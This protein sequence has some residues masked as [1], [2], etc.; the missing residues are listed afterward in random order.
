MVGVSVLFALRSPRPP[1]SPPTSSAASAPSA[2][3]R[4]SLPP[5]RATD[6]EVLSWQS[7]IEAALYF[8][9][10]K[11]AVLLLRKVVAA[12]SDD[13]RARSRLDRTE[14][15][16]RRMISDYYESGAREFEK[17]YYD[18]AITEWRKTMALAADFDPET[19]KMAEAKIREAQAKLTEPSR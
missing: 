10:V 8:D 7:K 6:D 16:L 1:K 19:Y 5:I 14:A 11:S 2:S 18:R 12:R 15:R 13:E 3:Q 4:K 9:D 17:L